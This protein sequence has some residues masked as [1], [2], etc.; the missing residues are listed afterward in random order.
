MGS[1]VDANIEGAEEGT[2]T[3]PPGGSSAAAGSEAWASHDGSG[4]GRRRG[5]AERRGGGGGGGK[6]ERGT[7]ER[8]GESGKRWGERERG[9]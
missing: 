8:R 5:R 1:S 4:L 3:G 2:S 7:V 6:G 9:W